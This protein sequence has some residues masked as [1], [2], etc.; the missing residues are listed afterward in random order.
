ML[1]SG[2]IT[3]F[4]ALRQIALHVIPGTGAYGSPMFGFHLYTWAYI[5]TTA[6]MIITTFLLSI[7]R[8]FQPV[9]ESNVFC[10][11]LTSGLFALVSLLLA[12]NIVSTFLN[13]D[14]SNVLRILF[15]MNC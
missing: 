2:F 7:D 13:A 9:N 1:I 12:A 15:D 4:I 8:Q 11:K 5:V 3:S 6:I 14:L 10:R